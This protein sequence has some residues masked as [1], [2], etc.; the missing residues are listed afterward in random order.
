MSLFCDAGSVETVLSLQQL[1]D[2][3]VE[4][5]AKLGKGN[6]VLVVPPDQSRVHSRAGD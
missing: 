5:L 3:L 4:S 1:H 6:R 2:L